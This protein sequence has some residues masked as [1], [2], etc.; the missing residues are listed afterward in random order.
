[1]SSPVT[2][3]DVVQ[4]VCKWLATFDDTVASVGS[5]TEG[6]PYIFQGQ[7]NAV[8]EGS[9]QAA[10]VF[11]TMGGWTAPNDYNTME[12]PR[13]LM[14]GWLDPLRD[15]DHNYIEP[16]ETRRRAVQLFKVFDHYLHRPS[17]EIV[18]WGTVRVIASVRLSE[19]V[20]AFEPDGDKLL[21]M[22]V[23]YAIT[24]G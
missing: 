10:V 17:R 9:Q 24:L 8:M 20:Y 19:P 16:A 4:G 12:F 11:S 2:T 13:L 21:R 1:M 15:A 14:D 18:Y 22:Q 5:T 7:L 3:D 23:F 6:S